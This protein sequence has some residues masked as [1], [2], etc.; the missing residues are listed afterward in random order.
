M[1]LLP[2]NVLLIACAVFCCFHNTSISMK[3]LRAAARAQRVTGAAIMVHPGRSENAPFEII[4][5][6][7]EVWLPLLFC[8]LR[9]QFLNS[10]ES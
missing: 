2:A 8:Y 4:D 3:V 5:I 7:R 6:L 10:I 9:M 1:P